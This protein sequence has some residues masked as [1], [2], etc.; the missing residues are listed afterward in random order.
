MSIEQAKAESQQEVR[1]ERQGAAPV[2]TEPPPAGSITHA[3]VEKVKSLP[4]EQQQALLDY[5][6][7]LEHKNAPVRPER[8][9]IGLFADE[10][11]HISEEDIAEA[12]REMWGNFPREDV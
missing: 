8:S 4:P 5:A 12:R 10:G 6:E 9:F 11:V 3:L 7:F 1:P 2:I